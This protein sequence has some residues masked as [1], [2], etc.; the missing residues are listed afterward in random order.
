ML[1]LK[2]LISLLLPVL[3]QSSFNIRTYVCMYIYSK[4]KQF[5]ETQYKTVVTRFSFS[6]NDNARKEKTR[7]NY[8]LI[9]FKKCSQ[10]L[11]KMD[12]KNVYKRLNDIL[13]NTDK[14]VYKYYFELK[15]DEMKS[16]IFPLNSGFEKLIK[17]LQF[18]NEL[19]DDD[20]RNYVGD[21][22]RANMDD[23]SFKKGVNFIF[24]SE[25]G[26]YFVTLFGTFLAVFTSLIVGCVCFFQGRGDRSFKKKIF[27]TIEIIEKYENDL[28][29]KK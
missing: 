12:E 22:Y 9:L 1:K 6:N 7:N 27:K 16:V 5:V 13:K 21:F 14:F 2:T 29:K 8:N 11:Q 20:L 3:T 18:I 26:V 24:K 17:D 19:R 15:D 25:D 10:I 23:P 28:K 4:E